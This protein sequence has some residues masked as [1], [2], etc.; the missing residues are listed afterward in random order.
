MDQQ[1]NQRGKLT[2]IG[3]S[4]IEVSGL[5]LGANTFGWTSD[6]ETSQ[7][8][9]DRY[10]AAGGNFI[11]TAD[12]YSSWAP[13]H[14]GGESE[15][16]LGRWLARRKNRENVVIATKVSQHPQ[17]QGL[18][19]SNIAAAA[20]ESLLRLGTDHIDVYYAHFD[21]PKTPLAETVE[22]FD[23]LVTAGKIRAVGISNYSAERIEE[24]FRIAR[25]N[26]FALPIAFEPH[27]NLVH[28][29]DYEK[30][31]APVAARE[32]LGVFPYF[33]LAAGFLT[34]KYRSAADA[35]GTARGGMVG[36]Y[37]NDDGFAV[38]AALADIAAAHHVQIASVS[39][40]WLRTRPQIVAPLASARS[41]EQLPALLDSLTLELSGDEIAALDTASAPF[42]R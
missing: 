12:T 18:S 14:S 2:K 34:G 31:L 28:R 1:V 6:E 10:V 7:T 29:A 17:Y 22:A 32:N 23:K 42:A 30:S 11:D 13:G 19:A 33:S 39:L 41:P 27:Y 37:L 25:E 20:D 35:Q 26:D 8:V 24:W 3:N 15:I 40:A 21:D 16:I 4:D 9:L 36:G 38:V 5:A